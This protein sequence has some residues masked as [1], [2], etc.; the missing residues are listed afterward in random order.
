M[1]FT[2]FLELLPEIQ[3]MVASSCCS[4][5]D[6][7]NLCQTS[8]KLRRLFTPVLYRHVDLSLHTRVTYHAD[9]NLSSGPPYNNSHT[10]LQ[11]QQVMFLNTLDEPGNNYQNLIRSLRWTVILPM[12][13]RTAACEY[14]CYMWMRLAP[15][16]HLVN[17]QNR[18]DS[19]HEDRFGKDFF[20]DVKLADI[21]GGFYV[22]S[23]ALALTGH[24][25]ICFS[26]IFLDSVDYSRLVHLC[27]DTVQDINELRSGPLLDDGNLSNYPKVTPLKVERLP[28]IRLPGIMREMLVYLTGRCTTLRSLTLKKVGLCFVPPVRHYPKHRMEVEFYEAAAAFLSSVKPTLRYLHY[29]QGLGPWAKLRDMEESAEEDTVRLA[30]VSFL[31]HIFPVLAYGEWPCLEVVEIKGCG[32]VDGVRVM[33]DEK[34]SELHHGLGETVKIVIRDDA[35]TDLER[36]RKR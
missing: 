14:A 35:I 17:G 16:M 21:P 29:D 34:V 2:S 6:I 4:Q 26:T 3:Q 30:D 19:S 32:F 25:D 31:H 5:S 1:S 33:D 18:V 7:S 28:S 36:L 8:K 15:L 9:S 12:A 10:Q 24:I 27:L 20:K 22:D 23:T 11:Y 13:W